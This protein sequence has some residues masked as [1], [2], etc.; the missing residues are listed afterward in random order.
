LPIADLKSNRLL[1]ERIM[2]SKS[3]PR[4]WGGLFRWFLHATYK[5]ALQSHQR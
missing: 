2:V 3:H 4:Q 1:H 5:S